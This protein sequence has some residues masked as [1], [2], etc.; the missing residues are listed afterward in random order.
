MKKIIALFF[1]LISLNAEVLD[2][3]VASVED[4]PITSYEV[5]QLIN[6]TGMSRN[7]ALNMLVDQK[8]IESEIK[9]R[10]INV[11]DFEIEN[12]MEKIAQ[13][14]GLSLFEFKNILMQKGEY[15]K[16]RE[17]LKQELLK[18]KLFDQIVRTKLKVSPEEI[19]SYYENNK[20]DFKIFKTIQV[21]KYTANNRQ[22]LQEVK[23]NP[24]GQNM[25]V[26]AQTQVYTYSELPVN[27]LFLFQQTRVGQFTPIVNDGLGYS[28]YYVSRKD[29]SEYIP[30][31]K[32]KDAIANKIAMQKRE[33]ILKDYFDKLKN[34]A[35][36]KFYN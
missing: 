32:V 36:I 24:L 28:M 17:N 3:V 25:Q 5:D 6:K 29:G 14:N 30:F 35:Y 31:E 4:V 20:N 23:Q 10:N 21:T 15:K 18:R 7:K 12:A 8:L 16:F 2:K 34:R 1:I 11:D 19:K 22:L 27:L 26:K 13:R 33:Q 9:K